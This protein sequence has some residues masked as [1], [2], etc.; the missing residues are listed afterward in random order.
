MHDD[1]PFYVKITEN[2]GMCCAK[3][4]MM[5]LMKFLRNTYESL[6]GQIRKIQKSLPM[7]VSFLLLMAFGLS[8]CLEYAI[9]WAMRGSFLRGLFLVL[10]GVSAVW[11]GQVFLYFLSRTGAHEKKK[12]TQEKQAKQDS[13]LK[14]EKETQVFPFDILAGHHCAVVVG[15]E[16][17][18][19]KTYLIPNVIGMLPKE[20]V[21]G[22]EIG[23]GLV[24][25]TVGQLRHKGYPIQI[26]KPVKS[27][28]G[29]Y[30]P[31]MGNFK[32]DKVRV[33][34]FDL[35]FVNWN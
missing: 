2:Y 24:E 7:M 28:S 34:P 13:G 8:L 20:A 21:N 22:S 11:V 1:S 14:Q 31:F 33:H 32:R 5:S 16:L 3:W 35:V 17:H 12:D 26:L 18:A 6:F 23:A 27:S 29:G 4:S 9:Q 25:K 10:V 15:F 30:V 19:P